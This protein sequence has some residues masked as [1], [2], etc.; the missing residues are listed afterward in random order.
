MADQK[1]ARIWKEIKLYIIRESVDSGKR[2]KY[3]KWTS[4]EIK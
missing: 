3:T 4:T 1:K 2:A